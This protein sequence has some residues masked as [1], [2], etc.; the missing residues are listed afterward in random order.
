MRYNVSC[1]RHTLLM[2]W[3]WV[4]PVSTASAGVVGV[5]FTWLTSWQGKRHA[6]TVAREQ[7][8]HARE[9]AREQRQQQRLETAY[10][11][12]L[13]EAER[14]GNWATQAYSLLFAP[15]PLPELPSPDGWNPVAAQVNA[16]GSPQVKELMQ[17]WRDV[18]DQLTEL[19][20]LISRQE[21]PEARK[22][23]IQ[24]RPKER[25]ARLALASQVASELRIPADR[26]AFT[27]PKKFP[28]K[29]MQDD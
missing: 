14:T 15:P 4:A 11:Q 16:F 8:V 13:I 2:A 9:L 29:T 21:R 27:N 22:E 3:E 5:F 24:L 28:M 25:K 17:A 23:F 6:E 10:I 18:V 1:G 19:V 7:H 12:M 20:R 26:L